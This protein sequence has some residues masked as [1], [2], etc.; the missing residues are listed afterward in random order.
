MVEAN[1]VRDYR[2]ENTRIKIADNCCR[3]TAAEIE[4]IMRRITQQARRHI[5]AAAS[6]GNYELQ[7]A[8]EN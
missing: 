6:T 2:I 5:S 3:R 4:N 7:T 1:I 8:T